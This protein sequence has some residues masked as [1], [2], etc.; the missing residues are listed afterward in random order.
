MDESNSEIRQAIAAFDRA[1]LKDYLLAGDQRRSEIISRFP[2]EGWSTLPLERYALG[3]AESD[4]SF[5]NWLERKS[6]ELGSIRGGSSKKLLVFKRRNKPGWYFNTGLFKNE[7]EA[8][9]QVRAAFVQ[10]FEKARQGDW[11]TIDDLEPLQGGAALRLKVL[12]VYF[13]DQIFPV[14]S[15]GHIKHFLKKLNHTQSWSGDWPAVRLNRAL[16]S[17]V[18]AIPEF[19][20]WASIEVMRFLY[21]WADPRETRKVVKIA[22]GHDSGYWDDCLKNNYI[23]VG[24]DEVGDLT[25]FEDEDAF[26]EAFEG[27][28]LQSAYKGNRSKCTEKAREL[29]TLIDLEPGDIVVANKGTSHVLAIGE[30]IEPGY[31][32]HPEREDFK[33]AVRVKWDT[34]FAKDIPAQPRWAL[35]TVLKVPSE[36][37]SVIR[38][39]PNGQ[40]TIFPPDTVD[41]IFLSIANALE[42]KGQVI[43]YGPPGTG[44]TYI[45]RRFAVWWLNREAGMKDPMSLLAKQETFAA[46]ER[47]LM[48][49]EI[50]NNVWWVVANPKEWSWD[51]LFAKKSVQY[52]YGRLQQNYSRLQVGDLVVGYQAT[53][54]K[55]IVALARIKRTLT[56]PDM[57]A[58]TEPFIELELVAPIT[59]GLTYNELLA[60]PLLAGSEPL[61]FRNQGTLF[62]LSKGEAEHL[63]A[64]LAERDANILSHLQTDY[65]TVGSL[66]L[67]TFHASYS[68]E[69]FVEGYRPT[70]SGSQTL[71]L[72]LEDGL[73]KKVCQQAM[74][75]PNKQ[76]LMLIDEI[77]RANIAKVFGELITLLEKDKRGVLVRLPQSR[78]NFSIPPNVYILGTMNTADRSI[79]LLDAALRR[80][81]AFVELMPDSE[82]LQGAKVQEL[83][84]DDFLNVLNG[85]ISER[86]GREKQI[87]HSFLMRNGQPITDPEEFAEVFRQDILPLLQEYC[88]DNYAD[89]QYF[90]GDRIVDNA[91]QRLNDDLLL[92]TEGLITALS[93]QCSSKA[94]ETP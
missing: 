89:L 94:R 85:R 28:Y 40:E 93:E 19:A 22:P 52:R 7:Q 4:D 32:W 2:L 41:P 18:R 77:N 42:R 87:G 61:R 46:A 35:K 88:Y 60:D 62:A 6:A 10:A 12:Y 16:L 75:Q 56:I 3:T 80:R 78:D 63:F 45:A 69:D 23:C 31:E 83:W 37:Y 30:V 27:A 51:Q 59:N 70:D 50:A 49:T 71:Q 54:D 76:F 8:W 29:W 9:A 43:L 24:W 20:G 57:S 14:Y 21:S 34:S 36:L 17:C 39:S 15:K 74:L 84:L 79:K 5:C 13:P 73:F 25:E 72:R 65:A 48:T 82:Q 81:F 33:H 86:E 91:S 47:A 1:A 44:K 90:L 58:R 53:P 55:R 66:T 38:S 92:N 26:R 11:D 68:Y 67:I 64:L